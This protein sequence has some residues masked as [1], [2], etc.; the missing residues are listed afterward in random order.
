MRSPTHPV[1]RLRSIGC[2]PARLPPDHVL[3]SLHRGAHSA[4]AASRRAGLLC[5]RV[6]V[7]SLVFGRDSCQRMYCRVSR[8]ARV[9]VGA[10]HRVRARGD[11]GCPGR[12]GFR[13][14]LSFRFVKADRGRDRRDRRTTLETKSGPDGS[15]S[16]PNVP[17]GPHHLLVMAKGFVPARSELTV[18]QT[19]RDARRRGRSRAALQRSRL[20]RPRCEES[21]R[22][23]S[24][25]DRPRRAGS[26]QA[27]RR[28]NR[29]DDGDATRCG[30]AIVR[31]G[32]SRPVI[33]GLDGDRVLILEDGQR[34]GDLSS[35]SGDHGV[36]VNPAGASK[37]E[38]VRGP[39]TLLYGSN[40]IGGL[41]NVISDT[42]PTTRSTACTA[43]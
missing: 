2:P 36:I 3:D 18:A 10:R 32:P 22:F 28:D 37:I 31:P 4:A 24:T 12:V 16:I 6:S 38:V 34:I 30:R 11:R 29:R 19:A 35:Q 27:T 21:V 8:A 9:R 39:A 26:G 20:G 13:P 23:L 25:H 5:A 43:A 14:S 7:Y 15:Y 17:A 41:V 1:V 33:R 40:A 42:I